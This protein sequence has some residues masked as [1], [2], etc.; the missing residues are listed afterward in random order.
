MCVKFFTLLDFKVYFFI[1][2]VY[3]GKTVNICVVHTAVF[4]QLNVGKTVSNIQL[5]L[6]VS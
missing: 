1:F 2:I 4:I 3:R 6:Q 5:F